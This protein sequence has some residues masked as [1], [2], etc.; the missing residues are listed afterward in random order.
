MAE[1]TPLDPAKLMRALFT[2]WDQGRAPAPSARATDAPSGDSSALAPA[3]RL[4]A[5]AL[6]VANMPSREEV[7]GIA[8]RLDRI[9]ALLTRID[10]RL[11]TL[12]TDHF[13]VP[14]PAAKKPPKKK[15]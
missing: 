9:E 5:Q 12:E 6:A 2:A 8:S 13:L 3:L 11:A 10:D 14:E 15:R 1:D 4:M 7:S